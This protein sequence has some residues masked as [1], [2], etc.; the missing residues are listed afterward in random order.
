MGVNV[1]QLV[2]FS[3]DRPNKPASE[4][5][6]TVALGLLR[7][8]G[9]I[10]RDALGIYNGVAER[11]FMVD[12]DDKGLVALIKSVAIHHD[13]DSI[14]TVDLKSFEASLVHL[15]PVQEGRREILGHWVK[16]ELI[17]KQNMTLD[18]TTLQAYIVK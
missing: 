9:L 13:Q 12:C 17:N 15:K 4:I 16:T 7:E 18:L 2:V 8:V 3:L 6:R 5:D 1:K 10:P 11:S 14:L